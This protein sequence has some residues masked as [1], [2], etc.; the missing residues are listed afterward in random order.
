MMPAILTACKLEQSPDLI[1]YVHH[2]ADKAKVAALAPVVTAA[3]RQGDP[4]ALD[5]LQTGAAELVLLVRSVLEQSPWIK[6][7]ALVLAGGVIE[8]DEILTRNL[9]ES[10]SAECPRLSVGNPKGSALDGAC[11]LARTV[12]NQR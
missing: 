1:Q 11:M 12:K 9:R 10:L 5:I 2:D 6:N 7:Q 4:L 8:H 3:A